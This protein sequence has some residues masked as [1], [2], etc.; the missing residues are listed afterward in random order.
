[1]PPSPVLPTEPSESVL[2]MLKEVRKPGPIGYLTFFVALVA[3]GTGIF[4]A[5]VY[6]EQLRTSRDQE[7][8]QFRAYVGASDMSII[9]YNK[10]N[11]KIKFEA[12]NYG[13]TPGAKL[14]YSYNYDFFI[15]NGNGIYNLSDIN[16]W[17]NDSGS[18]IFPN[19]DTDWVED[20]ALNTVQMD[21][22]GREDGVLIIWGLFK[23]IDIFNDI[24]TTP[25]CYLFDH[26]TIVKGIAIGEKD[27]P[28]GGKLCRSS[29]TA[30]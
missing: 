27:D 6:R 25:Y 4:S 11:L 18:L 13:T 15:Q 24:H 26:Q 14:D 19:I 2:R 23:Y 10:P 30:T 7:R 16:D 28:V 9:S 12:K 5:M 17:N 8:F 29:K 21:Y 1:M 22:L 3:A 20:I